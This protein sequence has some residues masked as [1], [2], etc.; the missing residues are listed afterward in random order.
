MFPRLI[1]S[2]GI[3]KTARRL[4]GQGHRVPAC[5]NELRKFSILLWHASTVSTK[6]HAVGTRQYIC[7]NRSHARVHIMIPKSTACSRTE[8]R[9]R[10]IYTAGVRVGVR[11]GVR[12]LCAHVE[13]NLVVA[14][15]PSWELQR[16]TR[17][18][19][20]KNRRKGG[21]TL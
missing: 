20:L 9:K 3:S 19:T 2:G 10:N 8:A 15:R 1:S 12:K 14:G 11:V 18:S 16:S 5:Q 7:G 13:I 21:V 6:S 4:L 17:S